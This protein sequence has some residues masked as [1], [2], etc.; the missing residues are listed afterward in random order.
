MRIAGQGRPLILTSFLVACCALAATRNGYYATYSLLIGLVALGLGVLFLWFFRDPRR[1]PP[2]D[3]AIAVAPADGR[4]IETDRL[5]DGRWQVAIFL[6]LF[7]VHVNR[8]PVSGRIKSVARRRGTFR[9]ASSARAVKGNARVEVVCETRYGDVAWRQISGL[10]ARKISC[11][12]QPGD[13]VKRGERFGLIYFGSRMDVVL[14]A[15]FELILRIG[16]RVSA[17][18]SVIA[19]LPIETED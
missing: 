5:P 18:E 15:S 1:N 7:D 3:A 17:G 8:V 16:D 13:N 9:P 10:V 6:S 11:R 2:H 14:P 12:L 19:R 4:I